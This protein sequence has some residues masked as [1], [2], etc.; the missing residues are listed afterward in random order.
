MAPG[1]RLMAGRTY[2]HLEAAKRVPS[3]YEIGTSRLLY[4]G[5]RGFAVKTPV[6]D[7]YSRHQQAAPLDWASLERFRDPRETT[8]AKY[9]ALEAEREAFVDGLMRSAEDSGYD[10]KLNRAWLGRLEQWLPVLLYPCHGL[11]MVTAYV[12]QLAPTSELVAAFAFQAGDEMRRIQRLA[13]RVKQLEPLSPGFSRGK[14]HWQDAPPWQPLR[15]VVEELLV[16]YDLGEA[17]AAL[18]LVVAPWFDAFFV[19]HGSKLAEAEGDPLLSRLLFSL[20]EDCRWHQ[21]VADDL[22]R[23][24]LDGSPAGVEFVSRVVRERDAPMRR[25]LEALEPIWEARLEPLSVVLGAI[26]AELDA[27]RQRLGIVGTT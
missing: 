9:V 16:T 17:L 21:A 23:G 20:D 8:Y 12:G 2:W 5:E 13:Y 26:G 7:W 6:A 25:A 4:Y 11:Q 24:L 27:R 1:G 15:R 10:E 3:P 14:Q 19:Q 22:W 18:T